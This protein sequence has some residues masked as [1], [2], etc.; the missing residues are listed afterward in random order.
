M[1]ASILI[2]IMIYIYK[3]SVMFPC[4]ELDMNA[5]ILLLILTK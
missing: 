5:D 1:L 3:I 2:I 4:N